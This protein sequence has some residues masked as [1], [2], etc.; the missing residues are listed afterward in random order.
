MRLF[1]ILSFFIS[2]LSV[3]SSQNDKPVDFNKIDKFALATPDSEATSI[4]RLATYLTT[5]TLT[6]STERKI[7]AIYVWVSQNIHYD[8]DFNLTSPFTT[9]DVVATQDADRVLA[10]RTGVCRGYANLFIALMQSAG[11]KAEKVD[12]IIKQNDGN[13]P[14]MGHSWV[15]VRLRKK[16]DKDAKAEAR[17]YLCDPTWA[18][19]ASKA[20][21]GRI[22]DAYFL[23]EPEDFIVNHLPLDPMWQL[24]EHP[25]TVDVFSKESA[26]NIQK[27]VAKSSKNPFIYPDTIN[28][29][30]KMDSLKRLEK[31]TWR[32]LHYNPINDYIWFEV[33]KVY[34][35][36]FTTFET[37]LVSLIDASINSSTLLADEEKF[38]DMLAI[39]RLYAA[40]FKECF[41]KIE[42][43]NFAQYNDAYSD[44]YMSALMSVYRS[45][46]QTAFLN[47]IIENNSTEKTPRILNMVTNVADKLDSIFASARSAAKPLTEIQKN[48]T[49]IKLLYIE[50]IA[51]QKS[52]IFLFQYLEAARMSNLVNQQKSAIYNLLT[53]GHLHI[54]K[55]QEAVD[56]ISML[57]FGIKKNIELDD[58]FIDTNHFLYDIEECALNGA[59]LFM[60]IQ[61]KKDKTT[62][63]E[64][65]SY[66]QEQKDIQK[67]TDFVK[68]KG[69][70]KSKVIPVLIKENFIFFKLLDA[71]NESKLSD[72][73]FLI[74]ISIWN[75]NLNNLPAVKSQI[76][77]YCN[78]AET[79][80]DNSIAIYNELLKIKS[81]EKYVKVTLND[82]ATAKKEILKLKK[83]SE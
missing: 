12:G 77:S 69:S 40:T 80:I 5:N 66:V 32:M 70:A 41:A 63:K 68:E 46:Y 1:L 45:G 82:L 74:A 34:S 38:E 61:N 33:G 65:M 59:F 25:T 22:N 71:G 7:R 62:S 26:E 27:Y 75:E 50:K 10:Q 79:H 31:A 8:K 42:D 60:D 36:Y 49:E 57:L 58:I 13:I 81:E 72:L 21:Y 83:A 44:A 55:Y 53:K 35:N 54:R 67:C 4:D 47:K 78:L 48:S 56:S 64:L 18:S 17:W 43:K 39:L 14:Q 20:D 3:I 28:R 9:H 51:H 76:I 37:K 15:A 29:F 16:A 11:L 52:S 23:A 30:L 2:H 73:Y 24:L 6:G 19:P